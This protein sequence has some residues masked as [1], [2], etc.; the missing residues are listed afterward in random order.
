MTASVLTTH[1]R[2]LLLLTTTGLLALPACTATTRHAGPLTA[3]VPEGSS[4]LLRVRDPETGAIR[5]QPARE[6]SIPGVTWVDPE[7]RPIPDRDVAS[8]QVTTIDRVSGAVRGTLLG[9][10]PGALLGVL[11]GSSR[12]NDPPCDQYT[13]KY[14]CLFYTQ[15]SGRDKAILW[16]VGLGFVGT[17]LGFL[18][19]ASAGATS[20]DTYGAPAS[21]GVMPAI[22]VTPTADGASASASW[23]F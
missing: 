1:A 22:A 6:A 12:G 9:L 7:G 21:A 13:D 23:H 11:V 17:T 18:I 2:R 19:G 20:I 16:G 14:G 15:L 4:V 5:E 10:V 3:R 8:I